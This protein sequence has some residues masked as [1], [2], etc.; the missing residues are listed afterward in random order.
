M[1]V[2]SITGRDARDYLQRTTSQDFRG[3]GPDE[4]RPG[5][6]L[7]A[8]GGVIST[9]FAVHE[10]G[11]YFLAVPRASLQVVRTHIDK[12]HFG[13]ELK[14]G[15]SDRFCAM[16]ILGDDEFKF[17]RFYKRAGYQVLIAP[18]VE[19]SNCEQILKQSGFE[20][21]SGEQWVQQKVLHFQPLDQIDLT[22]SNIILEAGLADFVHRNKGCYPGQEVIERIYT[23]GNI[24]RKFVQFESHD[25]IQLGDIFVDGQKTGRVTSFA[26]NGRTFVAN[27]YL[28]RIKAQ[29]DRPIEIHTIDQ[30]IVKATLTRVAPDLHK[31]A[32]I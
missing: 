18:R 20:P 29:P 11:D 25:D 22:E 32:P 24:P 12:L 21:L 2:L 10:G 1:A 5:A 27:G 14:Y 4:I 13:E 16:E 7:N 26:H 3:F 30:K 15:E 6:F 19:L 8:T 23:Y 28:L 9:F 17:S 31:D